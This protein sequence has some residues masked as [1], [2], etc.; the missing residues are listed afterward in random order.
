MSSLVPTCGRDWPSLLGEHLLVWAV[1][2]DL[3][4]KL[5][6][7]ML[8]RHHLSF[9]ERVRRCHKLLVEMQT[10]SVTLEGDLVVS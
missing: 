5:L 9:K 7:L 3:A 1:L 2:H 4:L 8:H 6:D 10:C